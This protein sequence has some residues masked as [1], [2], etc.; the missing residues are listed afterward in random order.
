M[1]TLEL[2]PKAP[3]A[4]NEA[5]TVERPVQAANEDSPT[6]G[7]LYRLIA[8]RPSKTIPASAAIAT[9]F[10]LG[11]MAAY[12]WGL[13][14]TEGLAGISR[15]EMTALAIAS[16]IPVLLVWITAF[17][18]WRGQEMRLMADALAQTA[19]RLTDPADAASGEIE[20]V[21]QTIRRELDGLKAGL[22]EA[23]AET[24]RLSALVAQELETIDRGTERAEARAR[25]MEDLLGRHRESLLEISRAL[26]SESDTISRGLRDQAA[27][28]HGLISEAEATL[29]GAGARMI[30]QT[31]ALARVSEAARAGADATASTLDRQASRLEVVATTALAKADVLAQRYDNQRQVIAEA[32][33]KLEAER[34]RLETVFDAHRDQM[35]AADKAMSERAREIGRA[36]ADLAERLNATFDNAAERAEALSEAV[37]ADILR[38]VNEMSE[39]SGTVSRSAGAATR[40]IGVTVDELKSATVAL[41]DDVGRAAAETIGKATEHLRS[42]MTAMS[43]DVAR[44]SAAMTNDLSARAGELRD[45]VGAAISESDLTAERFNA[46]MIRLGGTA[47]EAGR[48]IHEAT[49]ELETRIA[50]M[51]SEAAA[52]A[53]SLNHVLQEQVSAL[54]AIADI[55]VRHARVLDRSS[56]AVAAPTGALAAPPAAAR[57]EPHWSDAP[58]PATDRTARRW[59]ISDLLAAA[60]RERDAPSTAANPAGDAASDSEFHRSSLQVIETLQALAVDLDRALEQNPPPELW[61]RYQAGERNVFARRLYNMAGRQLYDRIAVKYRDDAEFREHVDRFVSLFERLLASARTRDRE[62]ILVETYLT[63]DTGKAYLILAQASGKLS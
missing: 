7:A 25:T 50:R 36:A 58:Q 46:A 17:A 26:G 12:V 54:A 29:Q 48:A 57:R 22:A 41:S 21:S 60:E 3:E 31:E 33:A 43:T 32:A 49:G 30:E 42:A 13:Y 51:P 37:S 40:A 10:C 16:S 63:S 11:I 45:L 23:L 62:N 6:A 5:G 2:A 4:V 24:T 53:A 61:Q 27:A 55:V 38:A 44:A 34:E 8:R 59:G 18:V 47:R 39:A 1:K 52:S 15:G 14:G 35:L 19:I 56:P 20:T 9:L 28:A